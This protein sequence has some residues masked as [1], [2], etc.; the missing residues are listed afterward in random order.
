MPA[1]ARVPLRSRA[2]SATGTSVPAG[3]N[4][5]AEL[6]GTGGRSSSP[7]TQ[8]APTSAARRRFPS[9]RVI[10]YSSAP[11]ASAICAVMCALEPKP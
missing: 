2:S 4:T 11:W 9:P 1:S 8:V 7:P 3:A 10:T 6:S 5:M